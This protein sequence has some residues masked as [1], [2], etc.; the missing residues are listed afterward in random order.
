MCDKISDSEFGAWVSL[1]ETMFLRPELTTTLNF[2]SAQKKIPRHIIFH[3]PS[4]P[5]YKSF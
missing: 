5:K 4:V 1:D 2:C 3:T